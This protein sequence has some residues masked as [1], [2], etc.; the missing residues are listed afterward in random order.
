MHRH[1]QQGCR[2]ELA[3]TPILG[4]PQRPGDQRRRERQGVEFGHS[5]GLQRRCQQIGKGEDDPAPFAFF[6]CDPPPGEKIDRPGARCQRA[7]LKDQQ[8]SHVIPQPVD[9][10]YGYEDRLDVVGE[11][12]AYLVVLDLL[13]EAAMRGIPERQVDL[14][15]VG[16]VRAM[17]LMQ[18]DAVGREPRGEQQHGSEHD[19]RRQTKDRWR[20][21]PVLG[22]HL[23]LRVRSA[24]PAP[25]SSPA[26]IQSRAM[27][28]TTADTPWGR[29]GKSSTAN[30][31]SRTPSPAG[32]SNVR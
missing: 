14:A 10:R 21:S 8:R 22:S 4:S 3:P 2:H 26:T 9:Q 13:N 12:R 27:I 20:P 28:A 16:L 5:R 1:Q 17:R 7:S 11:A 6:F 23:F 31:P 19:G 15:Q 18:A 32:V 30:T 25:R 24:R 29:I